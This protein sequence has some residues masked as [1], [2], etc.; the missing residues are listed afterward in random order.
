MERPGSGND[1]HS[2]YRFPF[3]DTV[4]LSA[5][6]TLT[7]DVQNDILTHFMGARPVYAAPKK[8]H[9]EAASALVPGS[10][11]KMGYLPD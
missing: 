4:D 1:R 2:C 11:S 10:G 5:N 7:A 9:Q 3:V 8:G 6:P